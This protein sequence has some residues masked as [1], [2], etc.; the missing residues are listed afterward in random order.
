MQVKKSNV[1]ETVVKLTINAAPAELAPIKQATLQ[2]LAGQV[3]LPGFREGKAPLE[4]IEKN[5]NQ[6][7]LQTEFL[8]TALSQLYSAA[9]EQYKLRPVAQP[10]V[11]VTKFVPFTT[12]EFE[13]EVSVVGEVK[14]PDY[15][16]TKK[17][18]QAPV[19][20]DKDVED[21]VSSLQKRLATKKDVDHAAQKGDEAWIDFTGTDSKGQPV[22]GADGKDY[23]LL[24][25][26]DT[27][28]PGFEKNLLGLKAG[29]EKTFPLTFPKDYTVK[30]LAGKK[31]TFKGTIKKVQEVIE[32]KADAA[33]AASAG[34]FK[35]MAE[36][37][38]DIKKQLGVERQHETD[39]AYENELVREIT[40]KSAVAV[41]PVLIDGQIERM[42][43]D[44][45][46]N[47][48]YR[49]QTYQEFLDA[50]QMTES[51][52]RSDILAP[53]A[54]EYVKA[55]LVLSEIAD[56]EQLD[57]TP[58]ELEARMQQAK[59]QYQDPA[60]QAELAKPE[61]RRNIAS[62]LL[63]EK[64]VAKIVAYSTKK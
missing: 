44:L 52:Y 3:K 39:R 12:L 51:K 18:K 47:L 37:K 56:R 17:S 36:L 14:L 41:P 57:I 13:V 62:Q 43:Q 8:D 24:L 45:R 25:G 54:K 7:Q 34:P 19:V 58:E 40:A 10:K 30:A 64:T 28:I 4:L 33:F 16:K 2:Q 60:M 61:A 23:P 15:K 27:F 31:I 9:L 11:S 55:G 21:V 1:S 5:V 38:K 35:S 50:Q 63:T 26:S 6:S 20:T 48:T 32:P 29:D 53:Q 49:G 42:L 22:K 46:Q 59:S